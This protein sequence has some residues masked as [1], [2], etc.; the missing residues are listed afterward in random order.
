MH[1]RSS[2]GIIGYFIM[3]MGL[4]MLLPAAVA[5]IYGESIF[6]PLILSAIVSVGVGLLTGKFLFDYETELNVRDGFFIVSLS[7][8]L[9]SLFGALP[10]WMSGEIPRAVDA[11]FESTSGFT[12]TGSTILEDIEIT[13]HGLLLWRSITQYIGGMGIIVLS[14][15]LLPLLGVGGMQLFKAEVPGPTIDKVKP[16]VRDTAMTLWKVYA[17]LTV[18]VGILYLAGGM[19]WFES[20][21][22]ALT[23]MATGGFSTRNTSIGGFESSYITVVA[24]IFMFFAGMNFVLHYRWMKGDYRPLLQST[25]FRWYA[26]ITVSAVIFVTI[27]T[28][29]TTFDSVWTALEHSAFQV[30]AILTTTGYGSYDYERWAPAVQF[31]LLVF[32]FIGGMA[33]S[34]A[35]GI[36]TV[37]IIVLIKNTLYELKRIIHPKAVIPLTIN[38]QKVTQG[39]LNDIM[40]F[41]FIF[42]S[43]F[44]LGTIILSATG[45]DFMSSLGATASA[46]GNIGP[47]LNTVGP[48]STYAH[49]H[50]IAKITLTFCMLMGR[51]ELFTILIILSRGFWRV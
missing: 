9:M 27:S 33:G 20:L 2:I 17:L 7:W 21:C 22:H 26:G 37:R 10:F 35:G 25:E 13:S 36:K 5:L 31:L 47:G 18:V 15:A 46:M 6:F 16:R 51:L 30:V 4:T 32:M 50:D 28:M 3:F 29:H 14:I 34:T 19:T 24:T 42:V 11:W 12:T 8:I 40:A 38:K 45:L 44:L 49:L 39:I 1:I 48:A 23:T 43:V 41:I